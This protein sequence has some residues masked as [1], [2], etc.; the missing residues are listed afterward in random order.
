MGGE[1]RMSGA[2]QVL[3]AI[4]GEQVHYSQLVYV[5]W[6]QNRQSLAHGRLEVL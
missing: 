1:R 2:D 5:R 3:F 6:Q 4:R